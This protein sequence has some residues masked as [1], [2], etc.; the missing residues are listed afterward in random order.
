ML[1][2]R[3]GMHHSATG[4]MLDGHLNQIL[5]AEIRSQTDIQSRL[6]QGLTLKTKGL[7][8]RRNWEIGKQ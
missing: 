4:R 7:G 8:S 3:V 2:V 5:R 1:R 6:S